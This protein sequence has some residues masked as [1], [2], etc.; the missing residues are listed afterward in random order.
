MR[1]VAQSSSWSS[2]L[3]FDSCCGDGGGEQLGVVAGARGMCADYRGEIV[4]VE[5]G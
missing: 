4:R 2:L 5:G 3:R 1:M